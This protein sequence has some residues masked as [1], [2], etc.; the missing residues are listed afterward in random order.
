MCFT[1]PF[2]V[3]WLKICMRKERREFKFLYW[4]T[5][6]IMNNCVFI[7][8][9]IAFHIPDLWLTSC[10]EV[11]VLPKTALRIK[12]NGWMATRLKQVLGSSWNKNCF[13]SE[14][15]ILCWMLCEKKCNNKQKAD[16]ST[17]FGNYTWRKCILNILVLK[18]K[19]AVEISFLS[20]FLLIFHPLSYFPNVGNGMIFFSISVYMCSKQNQPEFLKVSN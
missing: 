20:V 11:K 5:F 9:T 12:E 1:S 10:V 18:K 17:L 3:S 7:C 2:C 16:N 4:S 6:Q 13:L 15:C 19:R 8:I 14:C